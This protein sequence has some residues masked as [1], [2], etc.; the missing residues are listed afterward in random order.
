MVEPSISGRKAGA[1]SKRHGCTDI[2][3][4]NSFSIAPLLEERPFECCKKVQPKKRIRREAVEDFIDNIFDPKLSSNP[5]CFREGAF[6]RMMQQMSRLRF[7][8]LRS[9]IVAY[10]SSCCLSYIHA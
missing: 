8:H 1:S 5:K 10:H 6:Q 3:G 7:L 2:F 9:G 4:Q